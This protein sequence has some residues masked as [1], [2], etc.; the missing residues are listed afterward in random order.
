ME[1]FR[2]LSRLSNSFTLPRQS[3]FFVDFLKTHS[4]KTVL[5][6]DAAQ[7][8]ESGHP[9]AYHLLLGRGLDN[10]GNPAPTDDGA[11]ENVE[12]GVGTHAKFITTWGETPM[13]SMKQMKVLRPQ[14]V[15]TSEYLGTVMS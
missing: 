6:G 5:G 1:G 15:L 12:S 8:V 3:D 13:E 7:L 14:W 9:L 4:K 11:R 10:K 2:I